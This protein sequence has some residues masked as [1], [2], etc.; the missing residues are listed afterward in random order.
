MRF[1]FAF[2]FPAGGGFQ[3]A[4]TDAIRSALKDGDVGVMGEAV[5]E[6]GDAG[7]IGEDGVPLFEGFIGRQQDGLALVTV[8]NDF[9]E[10]VGGVGV[11][12]DIATFVNDQQGGAGVEA[13][14]A[15]AQAGG[16]ALQ[17]GKQV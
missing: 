3:L 2:G 9:E 10:Q 6:G 14:L 15:A 16:I 12:S 13:E 7:G 4:F 5:E 11:V 1:P 17:I 8:V